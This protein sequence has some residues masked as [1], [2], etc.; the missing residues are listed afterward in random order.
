MCEEE[1]RPNNETS[2][3]SKPKLLALSFICAVGALCLTGRAAVGST[4]SKL[5]SFQHPHLQKVHYS[6]EKRDHSSGIQMQVFGLMHAQLHALIR[7]KQRHPKLV[8]LAH[9]GK[10]NSVIIS[11]SSPPALGPH[12]TQGRKNDFRALT[13]NAAVTVKGR[14][15]GQRTATSAPQ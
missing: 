2:S 12:I 4:N 3:K 1:S 8:C 11:Q 15:P 7:S 13:K 9:K 10:Q 14:C 5:Q 6:Q